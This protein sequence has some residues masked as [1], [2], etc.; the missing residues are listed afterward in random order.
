[1]LS[2]L[3]NYYP[4]QFK[5]HLAK[6]QFQI[7]GLFVLRIFATVFRIVFSFRPLCTILSFIWFVILISPHFHSHSCN[8]CLFSFLKLWN[9]WSFGFKLH[10]FLLLIIFDCFFV[11]VVKLLISGWWLSYLLFVLFLISFYPAVYLTWEN[12]LY[13]C[14]LVEPF[15]EQLFLWT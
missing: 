10:L 8:S 13:W 9:V 12:S 7:Q 1:M 15:F 3:S 6:F 11:L 5:P 4:T 14:I 2:M